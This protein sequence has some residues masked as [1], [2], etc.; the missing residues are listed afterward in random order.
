MSG[1]LCVCGNVLLPGAAICF[2]LCADEKDGTLGKMYCAA[3]F[4]LSGGILMPVICVHPLYSPHYGV[5]ATR[6][7]TL[8]TFSHTVDHV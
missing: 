6:A 3:F 7:T 5:L 8:P 1:D 2:F 4:R